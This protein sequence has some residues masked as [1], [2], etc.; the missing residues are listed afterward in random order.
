MPLGGTQTLV[1][2]MSI[3]EKAAQ[4]A[5]GT[6]QGQAAATLPNTLQ[7]ADQALKLVDA[8]RDHPG[9]NEGVGWILG[10]LPAM[11]PNAQ[12]F[13]NVLGQLQGQVF[14]R[15]YGQLKGAGAISEIEGQKGEQA[16]AALSRA[17]TVDQFN[18]ALDDLRDVVQTGRTNAIKIAKGDTAPTPGPPSSGKASAADRYGQLVGGGKSKAEAYKIMHSEGY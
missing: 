18:K 4:Q 12:N 8:V 6:A 5:A 2:G 13:T 15:A 9:K 1:P 11:T 3:Q 10:R 7:A 17:Q 16:I 14:L